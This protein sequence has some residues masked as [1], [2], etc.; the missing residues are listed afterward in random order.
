[1]LIHHYIVLILS[2]FSLRILISTPFAVLTY[3]LIWY[4]PPVEQGKVLWYL[5]FYCLFQSLQTVSL[6]STQSLVLLIRRGTCYNTLLLN[7]H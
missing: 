7:P 1:M 2:C 5:V 3:F 6:A 4:V